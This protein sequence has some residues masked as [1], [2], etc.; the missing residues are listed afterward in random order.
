MKRTIC[1]LL[2]LAMIFALCACGKKQEAAPAAAAAEQAE[3]I[4]AA[5]SGY[6][7]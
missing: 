6:L 5:V 7:S 4:L 3:K 1:I 2:A